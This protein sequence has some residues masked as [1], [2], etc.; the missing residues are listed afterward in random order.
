MSPSYS[1]LLNNVS[2]SSFNRSVVDASNN[3]AN[4]EQASLVSGRRLRVFEDIPESL[5]DS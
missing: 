1:S 5:S 2:E 3:V 4:A